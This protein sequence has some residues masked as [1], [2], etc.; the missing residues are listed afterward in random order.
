MTES[1]VEDSR[2][3]PY[4]RYYEQ[5]NRENAD[6]LIKLVD[7][8]IRFS[9][10]F[11]DVTGAARVLAIFRGMLR[12]CRD[13]RIDVL[14]TSNRDDTLLM[15]WRM[16]FRSPLLAFNRPQV[17]EGMSIILI[18]SDGKIIEHRDYWDAASQIYMRIPLLGLPLRTARYL[19]RFMEQA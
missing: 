6:E 7:P 19:M 9:D 18:G 13:L 2:F 17:I 11:N 12:L 5:L 1:L 10:P 4:V 3:K 8:Q 14:H 15:H 16:S